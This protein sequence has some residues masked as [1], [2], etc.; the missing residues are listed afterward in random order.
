MSRVSA[1]EHIDAAVTSKK[2]A[3]VWSGLEEWIPALAAVATLYPERMKHILSRK[4][5]PGCGCWLMAATFQRYQQYLNNAT[6]LDGGVPAGGP[7]W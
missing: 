4:G 7:A 3:E 6:P 5:I 2:S 1:T